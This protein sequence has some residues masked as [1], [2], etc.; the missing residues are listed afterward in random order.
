ML[1]RAWRIPKILGAMLARDQP[2]GFWTLVERTVCLALIACVLA[3]DDLPAADRTILQA[4]T[5]SL[6]A[7]ARTVHKG[8]G[9]RIENV[10]IGESS[11]RAL[12]LRRFQVFAPDATV[13][14]NNEARPAPT[15]AYFRGTVAGD[16]ESSAFLA[17]RDDE[18]VHGLLF[19]HGDAFTLTH[20]R[21][22]SGL[23]ARGFALRDEARPFSCDTTHL[24]AS[25]P[26]AAM[27]DRNATTPAPPVTEVIG[28]RY[29]ARVA[30][31]T[32]FEYYQLFAG[33]SED[34]AV[35]E[36]AALE[37]MGFLIGYASLIFDREVATQLEI[38][39]VRLW[40]TDVDADPWNATGGT[41]EALNEVWQYWLSNMSHIERA[42]VHM[43][44]GKAL[45]GGRA[46]LGL[47]HPEGGY[48]ISASL[49][50]TFRWSANPSDDPESVVWDIYV[51]SHELGHNFGSLHTHEYCGIGGE[52]DPVDRC[53]DSCAGPA[54]GLPSCT[55]EPTAFGGGP[56]TLMS[57]CHHQGGYADTLSL[58]FG[59]DH[60]C[61][62]SPSRVPTVMR[63]FVLQRA[64]TYPDCLVA[65][66]VCGD[67]TCDAETFED[68]VTCPADCP[69][70][71]R[72]TLD[73]SSVASVCI[74]TPETVFFLPN[75]TV[76]DL[77][78]RM[79]VV[80]FGS[81]T[82]DDACDA[83][84][85]SITATWQESPLI[86]A[87]SAISGADGSRTCNAIFYQLNPHSA[88]GSVMVEYVG[89]S[90]PLLGEI[91]VG[92]F[93]LY[94][95]AQEAPEATAFEGLD[96]ATN[97]Q[98]A[99]IT[100]V[101]PGAFVLDI[102]TRGNP[103]DFSPTHLS[104]RELWEQSCGSSSSATSIR[105]AP[106]PGSTLMEWNHTDPARYAHS[107]IAIA[108]AGI[109]GSSCGNGTCEP[110]VESDWNCPVDCG[111]AKYVDICSGEL[112]SIADGDCECGPICQCPDCEPSPSCC[113]DACVA[114]GNCQVPNIVTTTLPSTTTTSTTI[115][116][117]TTVTT[118][119][120]SSTTTAAP[121]TSSTTTTLPQACAQ[122][123]STGPAPVAS[124]CLYIL[125][126]A[127]GVTT[128]SPACICAPKGTLPV[129][130][131]D[132][133][134]CLNAAVGTAVE[135]MCDCS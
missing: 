83:A 96:S 80:T 15:T 91:Q 57:Y 89:T 97:P 14:V 85:S 103:G 6:P 41:E 54:T 18:S 56:G 84:M 1:P 134:V 116:T 53:T 40:T 75:F 107:L 129:S 61:G 110:P 100:T 68:Y 111:C 66:P 69:H 125:N 2:R 35:R 94:D 79:L 50:T 43:L 5:P 113:A 9:L 7:Q 98:G 105:W 26:L 133:L 76:N 32:D 71:G 19:Y 130:A 88:S 63:N 3:A 108:P 17:V 70:L 99:E 30:V 11:D 93:V 104:Q 44:S 49:E 42:T 23:R 52:P 95:V 127:V 92:A 112:G 34:P 62:I 13:L 126:A 86:K 21:G 115:A 118:T 58:T 24:R 36:E 135:L 60:P 37:Y 90:E 123:V 117:S 55:E 82:P 29:T 106:S 72:V 128:C 124:D 102:L 10:R 119:T 101:T 77:P 47:C 33:V 67:G 87:V 64:M 81:Q 48:G 25:S 31:E 132:A 27:T 45:Y 78:D 65:D 122:P 4:G 12:D 39:F 46:D 20:E 120:S 114:C 8:D 74:D 131:T 73:D 28:T 59:L 16:A 38:A 22:T 109:E 51:V 121:S